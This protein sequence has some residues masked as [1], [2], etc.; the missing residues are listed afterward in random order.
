[1]CL[2]VHLCVCVFVCVFCLG[3]AELRTV[4]WCLLL[5]LENSQLKYFFYPIL[6]P[7]GIQSMHILDDLILSY[8]SQMIFPTF[9][10]LV[11][12]LDTFRLAVLKFPKCFPVNSI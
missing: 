11:L 8:R 12:S 4:V 9:F 1:M 10:S 7:F 2:D 5:F 3:F 6:S